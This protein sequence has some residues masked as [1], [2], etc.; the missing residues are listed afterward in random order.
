MLLVYLNVLNPLEELDLFDF[1]RLLVFFL[2]R[3]RNSS[4][5]DCGVHDENGRREM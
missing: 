3:S 1:G 5:V 2:K 4:A